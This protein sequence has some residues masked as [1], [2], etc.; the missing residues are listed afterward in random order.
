M[1]DELRIKL[2]NDI[3]EALALKCF[4]T[5]QYDRD[6]CTGMILASCDN[7]TAAKIDELLEELQQ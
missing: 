5:S 7:Y 3:R 4:A 2:I 6:F 1:K